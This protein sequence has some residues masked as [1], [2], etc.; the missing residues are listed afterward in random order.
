LPLDEMTGQIAMECVGSS[1]GAVTERP[2]L[3]ARGYHRFRCRDC[4]KQF[5]ERSDLSEIMLLRG[6]T[7]SHQSIRRWEEKL[8]PVMGEALGE[9]A[10]NAALGRAG[11]LTKL[12][13]RS[14]AAGAACIG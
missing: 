14:M 3:T 11:T 9:M 12:T 10:L 8:L 2:D 7:I 4:D 6:F 1:S 13:S 5:N